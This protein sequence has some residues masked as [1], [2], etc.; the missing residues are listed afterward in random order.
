MKLLVDTD[1]F[2]KL[3]TSGLFHDAVHLLGADPKECGRLPALPYM[4]RKDTLRVAYGPEG[5]DQMMPLAL[6]MP[7]MIQP[8]DS[9]LDK[10][11]PVQASTP[12]MRRPTAPWASISG[13][14]RWVIIVSDLSIEA[15]YP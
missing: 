15:K 7:I 3:A 4:L 13:P 9:W 10:L 11:T 12:T 6:S 2:C 5:C 8:D 14:L 1:V